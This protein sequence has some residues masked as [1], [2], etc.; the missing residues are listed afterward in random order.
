MQFITYPLDTIRTRL[1]VSGPGVYEG[2]FHAVHLMRRDEGYRAFYRGLAPSMIGIL[3]YAGEWLMHGHR[4]RL[5]AAAPESGGGRRG[6]ACGLPRRARAAAMCA[7]HV[8]QAPQSCA[9]L[10]AQ[11]HGVLASLP[12]PSAGVDICLFE[13]FKA[14]SPQLAR[15]ALVGRATHLLSTPF[16]PCPHSNPIRRGHLPV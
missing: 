4:L 8:S 5:A 1:A 2:I 11:T 9:C 15:D 10:A 16:L 3:P 7:D 13:L 6:E 12:G 14:C